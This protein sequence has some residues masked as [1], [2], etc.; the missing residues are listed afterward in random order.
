MSETH[1]LK[2]GVFSPQFQGPFHGEITNQIRQLCALKNH[3]FVGIATGGFAHYNSRINIDKLDGAI[4]LRNSVSPEFASHLLEENIP[5]VSIA[6][7]Y[8]PLTI[9]LVC[10]DHAEG[11]KL[12]YE[13][14]K[15][16]GHT[17]I[18]FVGDL[19][20]YDIRKR[21]EAIGDLLEADGLEATEELLY[22]VNSVDIESGKDA[23][24]EFIQRSCNSTGI[25]CGSGLTGIGFHQC[26]KQHTEIQPGHLDIVIFDSIPMTPVISPEIASIDQNVLL[27]AHQSINLIEQLTAGTAT[28]RLHQITPKL[29][30]PI[31]E[32][33]SSKDAYLATCVELQSLYNANYMKSLLS[34]FYEWTNDIIESNLDKIM[35]ISPLFSN[36]IELVIFSRIK[37]AKDGQHF[38]ISKKYTS[39][40][41]RSFSLL[42]DKNRCIDHEYPEAF[43]SEEERDTLKISFH[44]PIKINNRSWGIMTVLGKNDAS[45][46]TPSN[47][48]SFINY[49]ETISSRLGDKFEIQ[50]KTKQ[51]KTRKN[52]TKTPPDEKEKWQSSTFE[53]NNESGITTWNEKALEILGYRSS[54]EKNIYMHMDISDMFEEEDS[55]LIRRKFLNLFLHGNHLNFTGN[56]KRKS[57]SHSVCVL[58]SQSDLS[59]NGSITFK[60]HIKD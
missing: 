50:Y 27:M 43:L 52:T 34:N 55:D 13:H 25:I 8:F 12:A 32:N 23:C 54:F 20:N 31:T 9:P 4:L 56:I 2:I 26:V 15:S 1:A 58:E 18:A 59:K 49:M 39:G 36:F 53:F 37:S 41:T 60:V 28:P 6:Y 48:F 7:D 45:T 16:L 14:L 51:E 17:T 5:T 29:I 57:G 35:T 30:T 11:S 44:F 3:E 22:T 47:F 46:A 38:L 21:Y 19:S 24:K 42:D 40:E 10:S 33:E